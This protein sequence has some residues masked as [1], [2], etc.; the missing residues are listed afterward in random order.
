[1]SCLYG[2]LFGLN[3]VVKTQANLS[4][5]GAR[6]SLSPVHKL[7]S[8]GAAL[9]AA[10][11]VTYLCNAAALTYLLAVL[12]INFGS[13]APALYVVT[14]AGS[15]TGVS[16]G[17]LVG[18]VGKASEGIKI[19]GLS[20][21][22]LFLC[23]MSG[24]MVADMRQTVEQNFPWFNRIN[25]AALISDSFYSLNIYSTSYRLVRNI[26]TLAAISVVCMV[27]GYILTRRR[28]YASL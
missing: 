27:G 22:M 20:V 11:L 7:T 3:I 24:L 14:L 4:D 23:F 9:L 12:K 13:S 15:V 18:A 10:A 6:K 8:V 21:V 26:V 25:P 2:S 5:L 19:T 28:R 1:M 16:L 17:F